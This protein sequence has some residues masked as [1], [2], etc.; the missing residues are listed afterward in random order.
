MAEYDGIGVESR[1][2]CSRTWSRI[3]RRS[4]GSR[5]AH[6]PR[7]ATRS[8]SMRSAIAMPSGDGISA[9]AGSTQRLDLPCRCQRCAAV[10]RQRRNGL[11]NIGNGPSGARRAATAA[12]WR[13]ADLVEAGIRIRVPTGGGTSVADEVQPGHSNNQPGRSPG[14][15][16]FRMNHSVPNALANA[17]SGISR[18]KL[19]SVIWLRWARSDSR[20]A[21]EVRR[22]VDGVGD[23][24]LRHPERVAVVGTGVRIEVI[25]LGDR[26]ARLASRLHHAHDVIA[27]HRRFEHRLRARHLRGAMADRVDLDVVGMAVVAVPVVDRQHVGMLFAQDLGQSSRRPPRQVPAGTTRDRCSAPT[28]SSRCPCTRATRRGEPPAPQPTQPSRRAA[29]RP[30]TRPR[31]GL[32]EPRRSSP[33]VAITT[34]DSMPFGARTGERAPGADRLVIGMSVK[35]DQCSHQVPFEPLPVCRIT[36]R[37]PRD[38][39]INASILAAS[40]PQSRR[41]SMVC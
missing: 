1:T 13:C 31:R 6:V 29:D 17:S 18:K 36:R 41:I 24:S 12:A 38:P 37:R 28:P 21:V 7:I 14:S 33:S 5:S 39:A 4:V 16:P 40:K 22:H 26:R 8:H 25:V 32:R 15:A 35:A 30:A 3:A 10:S 20:L 34:H 9:T 2:A 27:V 19:V 23:L 11:V